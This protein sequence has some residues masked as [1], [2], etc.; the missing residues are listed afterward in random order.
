MDPKL[1]KALVFGSIAVAIIIGLVVIYMLGRFIGLWGIGSK[2]DDN[3]DNPVNTEATATPGVSDEDGF[4]LPDYQDRVKDDVATELGNHDL[5]VT[6]VEEASDDVEKG[7]VI[8]T[9]PAA[10][11]TVKDGDQI[12]VV[13]S[14]GAEQIS[15]PDTTGKTITDA[16]N[17]LQEKG[18]T[19]KQGDDVYSDQPVGKVAY[20]E[21]A[22]GKKAD[23][24]SEIKLYPSKGEENKYVSV[25]NLLGMTRSQARRELEKAGLKLGGE[26]KSYSKTQKNR[27]CE[28]SVAYGKQVEKG[29]SVDITLSLGEEKTYT[30]QASVTINNPFEYETDPAAEFEFVLSQDGQEDKTVRRA[31]MSYHNFPYTL[32]I[33]GKSAGSGTISVYKNGEMVA[34]Y[35]VTFRR[36]SG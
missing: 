9:N 25:P 34:S 10:G 22:A 24:G 4:V 1:E 33:T 28:Q 18:F 2:D 12:E 11:T 13:V 32:Q 6:F 31:T 14:S 20:T 35:P 36:V 30:Y 23:K 21:P 19:V 26:T 3:K 17:D 29:S 15:V 16:I 8:R 7:K 5:E 27:V